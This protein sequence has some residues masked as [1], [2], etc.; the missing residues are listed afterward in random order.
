MSETIA[1]FIFE[2]MCWFGCIFQ[3]TVDN[4]SEFK[5]ATQV[6]MDK[7]KVPI[8]RMLAYNPEVNGKVEWGHGIWIESMWSVKRKNQ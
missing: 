5:G 2:V 8:V 7:Y 4:S 6:L 3:L 1:Q